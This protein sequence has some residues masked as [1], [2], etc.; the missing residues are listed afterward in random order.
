[1]VGCGYCIERSPGKGQSRSR[2]RWGTFAVIQMRGNSGSGQEDNGR[3]GE[4]RSDAK[5]LLKVGLPI[6]RERGERYDSGLWAP[7]TRRMGLPSVDMGKMVVAA[8]SGDNSAG[9]V[10]D[11][12]M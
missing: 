3:D 10:V 9:L 5:Y 8:G 7:R 12:L 11:V 2:G 6:V 1:M 4:K